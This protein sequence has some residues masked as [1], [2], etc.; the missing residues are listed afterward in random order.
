MNKI[1]QPSN[2]F[3]I[4]LGRFPKEGSRALSVTFVIQ[5]GVSAQVDIDLT[6]W[7]LSMIQAVFINNSNNLVPID[8][9][10]LGTNQTITVLPSTQVFLPVLAA[11]GI[12][13]AI[14]SGAGT[15]NVP[16]MFFNVP[17]QPIIYS[18]EPASVVVMG[19]VPISGT[20]IADQ[21][22][23]PWSITG[24]ITGTVT[25]DQGGAW[26][27]LAN[28]GGA[29]W[30]ENITQFG[31][32]AIVTG[33]GVG[34]AGIPRVTVSNDTVLTAVGPAQRHL[35]VT[36]AAPLQLVTGAGRLWALS[37]V[38]AGAAGVVYDAIGAVAGTRLAITPNAQG[39]VSFPGGIPYSTGLYVAPGVAQ[40]VTVAF[41]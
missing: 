38:D 40:T 3:P 5:G 23:A 20:V 4:S 32:S 41:S 6:A 12:M 35:E 7:G 25:A 39:I 1:V 27:V 8:L 29:P 24:A 30:A 34:G 14:C 10:I 2:A 19:T 17:I 31:G 18:A 15:I 11:Q 13:R 37:I 28:Q 36:G 21:G 33:T 22:G 9:E 26:T 16:C